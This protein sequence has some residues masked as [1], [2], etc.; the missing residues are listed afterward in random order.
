MIAAATRVANGERQT[1]S[2]DAAH[3]PTEVG[4]YFL[5]TALQY[6]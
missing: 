6:S 1:V 5:L 4:F 3:F 2:P